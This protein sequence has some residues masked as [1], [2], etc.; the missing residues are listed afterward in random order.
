MIFVINILKFL[1][2]IT[3]NHYAISKYCKNSLNNV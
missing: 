2:G 3:L 1:D